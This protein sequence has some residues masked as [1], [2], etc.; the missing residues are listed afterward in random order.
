MFATVKCLP[1]RN[2]PSYD[3]QAIAPCVYKNPFLAPGFVERSRL[4]MEQKEL[5]DKMF[6][7]T[8]NKD[9]WASDKPRIS[10]L[11]DQLRQGWT[12]FQ[13]RTFAKTPVLWM[14]NNVI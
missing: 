7:E 11:D 10:L 6:G 3:I 9:V 4:H 13:R 14:T 2:Q 5:Y 12:V 8:P 1:P